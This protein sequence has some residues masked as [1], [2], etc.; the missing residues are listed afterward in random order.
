MATRVAPVAQ[1][2]LKDPGQR[3]QVKHDGF[4]Q[5]D[6][7]AAMLENGRAI[8]N[9][10]D[11][12]GQ[13]ATGAAARHSAARVVGRGSLNA[14]IARPFLD[15]SQEIGL[16][17][18][19]QIGG[20][21][22]ALKGIGLPGEVKLYQSDGQANL[23]TGLQSRFDLPNNPVIC[24]SLYRAEPGP[25]HDWAAA[26]PRT[27]V[28]FGIAARENWALVLPYAGPLY[29]M[30]ND[31]VEGWRRVSETERSITVPTLEGFGAG[32]RMLLWIACIRDRIVM[33]TDGF[34]EDV[35]IY[36]QPGRTLR[37]PGGPIRIEHTGGQWMVSMFGVRMPTAQIDSAGIEAGYDSVQSTGELILQTQRHPVVDNDENVLAEVSGEDTTLSR[38]DLTPTQRAW[39]ATIAPHVH[40]QTGVGTDP[41]TGAPVDFTT[42]VSP[43]L[44]TVQIGQYAE[45][46]DN[47]EPASSEVASDVIALE[48][49]HPDRERAVLCEL[50][51]DNQGGAYTEIEEHRRVDVRLG[52]EMSD[53]S[54]ETAAA[55]SGYIVEPPPMTAAGGESE[56]ALTLLDPTIRLRDEKADG[57]CPVFDGWAVIDVFRW[58]LDRCG[59]DRSEQVLEDTGT[60]LSAGQPEKPLWR[61]EP[62]KSWLEFLREVAAYDSGA[63]VFFDEQG[64]VVKACPHC[65]TARSAA[66]VAQH[67]GSTTGA[68]PSTVDWQL[69]TRGGEAVDPQAEGEVLQIRRPRRSLSAARDFANF[70]VVTGCGEDAE[71]VVATAYDSASLYD[72]SSDRYVGWR[73]MH[74]EALERYISQETVERLCADRF[75]ELSRRPEHI[76]VFTPLLPEMRIG[77]V[78]EVSGGESVG[79]E[80]RLYRVTAVRHRLDRRRDDAGG[81]VTRI[82]ARWLADE[83][84]Q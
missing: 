78:V 63:A 73:K 60:V 12:Q 56:L 23:A 76:D 79:A 32:Q 10:V 49:D 75:A 41:E 33:S 65:R 74:V 71:S 80:G 84:P 59:F 68:C 2:N 3:F 27:E 55:M 43:E 62:G 83:A 11:W 7:V 19:D 26:P 46:Q 36:E 25:D 1:V 58:V 72:P 44:Y 18:F 17:H 15:L 39:R 30:Y 45:V 16:G 24:L 34:A 28:H 21:W 47:G 82:T 22:Q 52:W 38:T 14:V 61:P 4:A 77:N 29:L 20:T 70:V 31:P 13:P 8:S 40:T 35:W 50:E 48:S 66:D 57:R 37:I 64:R 9:Y 5:A 69:Y 81:A 67:D 54:V 51:M 6:L 42:C 53:A